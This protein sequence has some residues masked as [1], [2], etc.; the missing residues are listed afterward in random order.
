MTGGL[1]EY[2]VTENVSVKHC[3]AKDTAFPAAVTEAPL[4]SKTD[5]VVKVLGP[6]MTNVLKSSLN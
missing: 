3:V 6:V 1:D 4:S 5:V 2:P